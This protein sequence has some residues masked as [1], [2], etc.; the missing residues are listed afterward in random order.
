VRRVSPLIFIIKDAIGVER[1]GQ[2][3]AGAAGW[4]WDGCEFSLTFPPPYSKRTRFV[5]EL[6]WVLEKACSYTN[7]LPPQMLQ[8]ALT[9]ETL[10]GAGVGGVGGGHSLGGWGERSPAGGHSSPPAPHDPFTSSSSSF[11][12]LPSQALLAQAL[13]GLNPEYAETSVPERRGPLK[14]GKDGRPVY[15]SKIEAGGHQ[16]R[17]YAGVC[18][19]MLTYADVY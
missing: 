4:E 18:W 7:E 16:V 19:R 13:E 1:A 3:G 12:P 8:E 2:G 9:R 6:E 11:S 17:T 5:E 15:G 10:A 14:L